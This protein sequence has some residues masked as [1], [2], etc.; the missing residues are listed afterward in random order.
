MIGGTELLVSDRSLVASKTPPSP[1]TAAESAKTFSLVAFGETPTD[2]AAA[3]ALRT[4]SISRPVLDRSRFLI[5][6]TTSAM[7]MSTNAAMVLVSSRWKGPTSGRV[8]VHP[9]SPL[10]IQSS[11]NSTCPHTNASASGGE[12]EC[13]T[14]ESDG[15]ERDE[16]TEQHRCR[17]RAEERGQPRE[18]QPCHQCAGKKARA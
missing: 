12:R 14:T 6:H 7:R 13:H 18:V 10:R 15:R 2:A 11:W 3:G 4:A 8:Y 17:D 5:I 16:N 1:A 9:K